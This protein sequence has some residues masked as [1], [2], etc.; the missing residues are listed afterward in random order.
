MNQKVNV[1]RRHFARIHFDARAHLSLPG[2]VTHAVEILDFSLKGALVRLPE[3]LSLCVGQVLILKAQ[4]GTPPQENNSTRKNNYNP[5]SLWGDDQFV[6]RVT[7][8]E[9]PADGNSA[10]SNAVDQ[11]TFITMGVR[12]A[13]VNDRTA[14]LRCIEIDLDSL[15]HLRRL[16]ELNLGDSALLCREL[17]H[18]EP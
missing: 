16:L 15:T 4:L 8:R 1:N 14:G 13:H 17:E 10:E 11:E 3:E 5:L 12:V 18:L 2:N 7:P 9:S 6:D